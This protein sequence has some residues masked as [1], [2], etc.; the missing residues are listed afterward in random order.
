MRRYASLLGIAALFALLSIARA[1]DAP[2]ATLGADGIVMIDNGGE[3]TLSADL[4][5]PVGWR[6][7]MADGPPRMVLELSDFSWNEAPEIRSTSIVGYDIVETGP[8]LSELHAVMREPLGILTAEMIAD[9]DG[10]A[11]LEIRLQPTTANAFQTDLDEQEDA[12]DGRAERLVIAI[13]PGHGGT[14][15]GAEADDIR[16]SDLV[17]EFA[18]RLRDLLV[19]SGKCEVVLTRSD[20]SLLSLDAR[21]SVAR[22]A[23]ADVLISLHADALVD[24]D[25]ASGIVIYRLDPDAAEA[26]NRRLT[27]RHGP[28]DRL[29]GVDLADAEQ[30]VNMA[31]LDLARQDVGP[32]ATA[33]SSS[34]VGT[35]QSSELVV[36]SRPE[37][38]GDFAVLK[39]A[40]IPS[41]L[42]ELGFLSTEADLKR[43]TSEDWQTRVAEAIRDGLLLWAEEDRLR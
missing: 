14:D 1:E 17:L 2:T 23:E 39:A 31:L 28:D 6:L 32:R 26:A 27:E 21:L 33:L 43:L 38:M 15:P 5:R 8:H 30:D 4:T 41:V 20:D 9:E 19:A 24:P 42:I 35:F 40:D 10:T 18:H 25:A 29:T 36:N 3:V 11:R 12:T 34:L 7:W 16:E 13:D 37:R 22:A